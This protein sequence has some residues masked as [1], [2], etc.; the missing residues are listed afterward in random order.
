MAVEDTKSSKVDKKEEQA[1]FAFPPLYCMQATYPR[2]DVALTPPTPAL[3]NKSITHLHPGTYK[4]PVHHVHKRLRGISRYK[5]NQPCLSDL[6]G[7][8]WASCVQSWG[9]WKETGSWGCWLAVRRWGLGGGGLLK[10][11]CRR[12]I[13]FSKSSLFSLL[14][15]HHV[16]SFPQEEALLPCHMCVWAWQSWTEISKTLSQNKPLIL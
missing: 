15:G 8:W 13:F 9:L 4:M 3:D 10:E 2:E 6:P 5:L 16:R 7:P 1:S 12:L 14:L 11:W